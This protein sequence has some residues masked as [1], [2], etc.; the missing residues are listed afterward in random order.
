MADAA[1][2]VDPS[3]AWAPPAWQI[4]VVDTVQTADDRTVRAG[5]AGQLGLQPGPSHP[6]AA[7]AHRRTCSTSPMPT[8]TPPSRNTTLTCGPSATR[9]GPGVYTVLPGLVP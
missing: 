6:P 5:L 4:D 3:G 1:V 8:M 7:G 2:A 9:Y